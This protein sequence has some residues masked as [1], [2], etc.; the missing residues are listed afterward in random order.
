MS[1]SLKKNLIKYG[2]SIGL[3]VALAYL[4]VA[5]RID[6]HNL[7]AVPKVELYLTL[8]DAFSVPGLLM[9]MSGLLMTVSN[10]GAMDGLGYVAVNGLKMLIPGAG[11]KMETFKDYL[12][13]RRANRVKGYGFLYV[14]AALCLAIAGVFMIL[15]YRVY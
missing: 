11:Q 13:R 7:S 14:T 10:Q 12:E 15:F 3:S 2:I 9:L 6:L 8:C 4:Y 1:R 5:L